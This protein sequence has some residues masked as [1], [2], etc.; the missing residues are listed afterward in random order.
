MRGRYALYGVALPI[1]LGS[2]AHAA[3]AIGA[4]AADA[5]LASTI[6]RLV[7][8][9]FADEGG[10]GVADEVR[11]IF[12][13]HGVPTVPMVGGEAAEDYIVLVA[14]GQGVDFMKTVLAALVRQA[15][16]SVPATAPAFLRVRIRQKELEQ[17]VREPYTNP[18]LRD[19]LLRLVAEDQ[20]VRKEPFDPAKMAAVDR[21]TGVAIE[22]IV[23]QYGVPPPSAVGT[24]A[25]K[26]LVVLVQHQSAD[27]RRR[28]LP[29]LKERVDRGEADPGDYAMM[30][31]RSQTDTGRSQRYGMNFV[32]TP[33]QQELAPAPIEDADGLDRRRAEIGLLP[34]RLYAKLVRQSA[35][36]GFCAAMVPRK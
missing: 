8:R 9:A 5:P 20:A 30:F 26:D 6:E 22:E 34:M 4:P 28:V 19:R 33:G 31:D 11:R 13:E 29:L 32:C 21:R 3:F 27:L 7:D 10:E 1:L 18:E 12:A 2:L 17:S 16:G 35:P 25:I 15:P 36:P 23:K 14:H 24:Q